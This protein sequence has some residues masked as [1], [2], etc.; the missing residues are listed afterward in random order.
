MGQYAVTLFDK[1]ASTWWQVA[2]KMNPNTLGIHNLCWSV[3]KIEM[4]Q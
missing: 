1:S 3:L 4:D 2:Q